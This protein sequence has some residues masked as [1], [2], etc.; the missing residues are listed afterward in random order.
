[1][2]VSSGPLV[3]NL[4]TAGLFLRT[5]DEGLE[6]LGHVADDDCCPAEYRDDYAALLDRWRDA[7]GGGHEREV[8]RAFYYG[9]DPARMN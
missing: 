9:I 5:P 6:W 4:D 3:L 2:L 7:L 8:D 1:M